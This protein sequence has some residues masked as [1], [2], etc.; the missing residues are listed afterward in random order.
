MSVE[1]IKILGDHSLENVLG[2]VAIAY[3]AGIKPEHIRKAVANFKGVE[4]RIEY[5]GTFHGIACYND[6]KATNPESAQ[7]AIKSMKTKGVL[8]AGGMDKGSDFES[9]SDLYCDH[10]SHLILLGETKEKMKASAY[11][12]G[13]FSVTLV[14][15]M[16]EA[17]SKAFQLAKP[18]TNILL[19]PACASWDMYDSFEVRGKDFK[20]CIEKV[21]L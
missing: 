9:I 18:G 6:S 15:T 8:I 3:L 2:A 11:E 14:D 7:V 16:E 20:T 5:V 13:F 12:A 17:V 4:H 1:E 21:R 10:L 19:S